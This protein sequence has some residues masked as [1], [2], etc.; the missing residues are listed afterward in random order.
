MRPVVLLL[1]LSG[2]VLSFSPAAAQ[3][4]PTE[5]AIVEEYLAP[6]DDPAIR[7]NH[8]LRSGGLGRDQNPTGE[9]WPGA[10]DAPTN[11]FLRVHL[12]WHDEHAAHAGDPVEADGSA[13]FEF[14]HVL[15]HDYEA[16]RARL[17]HPALVAWD[18][19]TPI[20][21]AFTYDAT[22]PCRAR[23]TDDPAVPLPSWAT[24]AGGADQDPLYGHRALC[25]FSSVAQLANALAVPGGFHESVHGTVRGEMQRASTSE[26][27]PVFWA[28]HRFVDDLFHSWEHVCNA[29]T[30]AA[31]VSAPAP[32]PGGG[33]VILTTALAAAAW[34]LGTLRRPW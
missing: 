18:P 19:A 4:G 5:L 22:P 12:A 20:P 3:A 10:A 1:A 26:K 24:L 6:W 9:P 29:T 30:P 8:C 16:W 31:E 7:G 28:F 13:F 32:V 17:G 21:F 23:A 34:A 27:D 15:V 2:G 11:A 14:H 25:Q 33:P